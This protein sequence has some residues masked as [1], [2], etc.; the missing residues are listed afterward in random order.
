M[1]HDLTI[2]IRHKI[3]ALRC[4]AEVIDAGGVTVESFAVFERG[5]D[6]V[7]LDTRDAV[8]GSHERWDSA[9]ERAIDAATAYVKRAM[10]GEQH[11]VSP[12]P[13]PPG[14]SA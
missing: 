1:L 3:E 10:R 8:H 13:T 11:P 7:V 4:Q 9:A 2:H 12:R 5:G 6:W 14:P